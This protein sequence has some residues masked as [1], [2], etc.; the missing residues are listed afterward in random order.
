MKIGNRKSY[1]LKDDSL[2]ETAKNYQ[3]ACSAVVDAKQNL[4]KAQQAYEG[5]LAFQKKQESHLI[6]L[7]ERKHGSVTVNRV[8]YFIKDGKLQKEL[9]LD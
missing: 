5:W 2:E 7:L 3:D 4:E 8:K 9:V 6:Q 1:K